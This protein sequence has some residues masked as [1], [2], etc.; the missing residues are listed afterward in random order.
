MAKIQNVVLLHGWGLNS[1]VWNDYVQHL[2]FARPDLV[3][4]QLDLPGYG[5]N[6]EQPSTADLIELAEACLGMAPDRAIWVGWSLGGLVAMQAALL[7]ESNRVQGLQLICSTPKFTCADDW[8]NGVDLTIFERFCDQFAGDYERA[9][10]MFLLL[11]AGSNKG[12]RELARR[13]HEAIC[14]LPKPDVKTLYDGIRCLANADLRANLSAL[15]L[16]VQVVSGKLDRVINSESSR[17]LAEALEA[18]L[19]E[20]SCGHS[21]FMSCPT[22][23]LYALLSLI[24]KLDLEAPEL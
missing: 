24:D 18:D 19:I 20:L 11:Q 5:R 2:R 23:V 13:A 21:P 8:P 17:L 7:D 3:V 6:V 10:T 9:L 1:A 4:Q 12:A 14:T 15:N 22:D 16:P